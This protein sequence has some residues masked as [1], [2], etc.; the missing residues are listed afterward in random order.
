VRSAESTFTGPRKVDSARLTPLEDLEARSG[1]A[2]AL[3]RTIVGSVLRP[4]GGWMSTAGAIE[5]LAALDVP[6]STA[7]SSLARIAA[8]GVLARE[9]RKGVAGYALTA[10]AVPMLDRGDRRIFADRTPPRNPGWCLLSYSIPE[11]HRDRRRRLRRHLESLGCGTVSDG[12]WIAPAALADEL[13]QAVAEFAAP[14]EMTLFTDALPAAPDLPAL[15]ATWYDVARMR[16]VHAAFLDRFADA[17]A[18]ADDREAFA[19]WMRVLDEWRV[20]PYVD[21]VL[22]AEALPADWPGDASAALF[23]ALRD[24]L[25]PRAL[26]HARRTVL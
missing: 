22:P 26:K 17:S 24:S 16:S 13:E 11:S 10:D 18:P 15:A 20:I 23:S 2:A 7:R 3:L 5:L 9:T 12:L 4:L 1:S 8:R 19:R 25:A 14:G 6:P 21:P